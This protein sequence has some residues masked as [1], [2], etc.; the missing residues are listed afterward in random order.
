MDDLANLGRSRVDQFYYEAEL[1]VNELR[2]QQQQP[3]LPR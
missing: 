2:Q 3:L 1:L